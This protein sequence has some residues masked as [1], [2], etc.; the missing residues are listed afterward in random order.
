MW[1]LIRIEFMQ[2]KVANSSLKP[3][4]HYPDMLG[5]HPHILIHLEELR[6][7]ESPIG[8][9]VII[10]RREHFLLHGEHK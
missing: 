5:Q 7:Q 4:Q 6:L 10:P 3:S 8:K 1:I 9:L 2:E